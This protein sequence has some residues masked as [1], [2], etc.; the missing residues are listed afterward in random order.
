MA[1]GSLSNHRPL[2]TDQQITLVRASWPD[3]AGRAD[4]LTARF[5]DRLFEIDP[6]A[7]ALFAGVDMTAQRGKLAR[8][9]AVVVHALDNP[10][11]L[12][13]A[14]GALGKRHTQYGVEHHHFDSVGSALL[15]ALEDT[16]GTAF[17]PELRDGWATA[18]ALVAAVMR[19]ALT[20][21][22]G[23]PAGA[24]APSA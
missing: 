4:T 22:E 3:I 16:L 17:T 15:A 24:I 12:L 10:D 14:L 21:G 19:R 2:V 9:L 23:T 6:T 13:P 18:Y 1:G 7:A 11:T 8:S 5:Y 20:R